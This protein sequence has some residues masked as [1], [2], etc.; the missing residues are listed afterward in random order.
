MRRPPRVDAADRQPAV[1]TVG[2][3]LAAA[4][5][6]LFNTRAVSGRLLPCPSE[7]F[8]A[9]SN[10]IRSS[11]V[12][13]S[14]LAGLCLPV[15][16]QEAPPP[17][18][19]AAIPAPANSTSAAPLTLE[20]CVQRALEHGFDI[21]IQRYNPAY[22]K[23]AV[24]VARGAFSPTISLN[25]SQSH[26]NTGPVG[27]DAGIKADARDA[28]L[29]ATE[30]LKT[31]TTVAVSTDLSRSA[32]NPSSLFSYYNPVYN[33]DLT[34]TVTQPLLR[35]AGTTV[36]TA[37]LNRAR[38]GQTRAGY[39]FHARVLDV[40]QETEAAYYSLVYAREQLLVF[41]M[42][43][44]LANRLLEEAQAKKTVGTATDIDVLQAQVGV[45]N[46]RSNVLSGEKSTK[47]T[48]DA[49]L[50]LIGRF[51]FDTTLGKAKFEDFNGQL[52]VIESSY[53][54]ALHNQPD[55]ISARMQLDQMQ[56]DLAVAKNSLKPTVNLDGILGFNGPRGSASDAFNATAERDNNSWE[57]DLTV[58]Y[59]WGR[60]S[61]KAR[62]RQSLGVLNQQRLTVRQ[63]EQNILVQ[64][65]SAV[66]AVE[67]NSE[68]V[69]IVALAAEFSAR[70]Y[71]LE[72]ARFSAGLATSR[73]V[74]QTQSDW[75]NARVAELQ[76][77]I[78]LQNSISALHRLE[79]SSLE[80]Y[81]I[82]LP[83]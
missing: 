57:V 2:P 49:L 21:E 11:F 31:G 27:G 16:S 65:R 43:L 44:D 39:D 64:V 81:H 61:D 46:A 33:S 52:P 83:E 72:N 15:C 45:A 1:G 47:D 60:I 48:A 59:P 73:D 22:A 3:S 7:V 6:I 71:D 32:S 82:T 67:T 18:A 20:E 12:A 36:T 19:P 37:T 53:Q 41:Q 38:I 54:L 63:L 74:L 78:T 55:Y 25:G 24:D 70:Q 50:A 42:S 77:R 69:K 51:E 8:H 76:A 28:R 4:G 26:S 29:S 68:K 13:A 10:R 14:L 9:M 66:R 17:A 58:S 62:Y 35:G 56:L 79:G 30:L 75:Q 23:D 5:P 34:V 40:V 80:R